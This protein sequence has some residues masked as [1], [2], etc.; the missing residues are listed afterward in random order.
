[1]TE[2]IVNL[3]VHEV[4]VMSNGSGISFPASGTEARIVER[5]DSVAS[6]VTDGGPVPT[7][8]VWHGEVSNLPPPKPGTTFLVSRLVA[9]AVPDRDDLVFPSREVRDASGRIIG[10]SALG[11]IASS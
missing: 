4:T 6:V 7:E 5:T 10:C 1:M 11:R 2:A 8:T 3:T 9:M